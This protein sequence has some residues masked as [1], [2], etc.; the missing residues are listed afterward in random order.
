[1]TGKQTLICFH[2]QKTAAKRIKKKIET[3]FSLNWTNSE[4]YSGANI[5]YFRNYDTFQW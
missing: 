2:E 4:Y 3:D 5:G 1:M